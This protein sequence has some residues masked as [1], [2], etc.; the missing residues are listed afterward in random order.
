[1]PALL[2]G[3]DSHLRG[4][5]AT[6][7][8]LDLGD[9]QLGEEPE[10]AAAAPWS[11]LA[12]AHANR[13]PYRDDHQEPPEVITIVEARE[14]SLLARRQTLSKAESATSSSSTARRSATRS[15]ERARPVSRRK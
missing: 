5:L 12:L 10:A 1:M 11:P 9:V 8:S 15:R 14:A 2:G 7:H 6:E 3:L 13:L 4:R